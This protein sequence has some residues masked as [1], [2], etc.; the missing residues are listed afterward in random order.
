M[1]VK[2]AVLISILL[3]LLILAA[4]FAALSGLVYA[5]G[6]FLVPKV[7]PLDKII[8]AACNPDEYLP[9][10][11]QFIRALTDY[12]NFL[13]L[14]PYLSWMIAYGLYRL[15]PRFK[16]GL[17]AFL[18]VETIIL[19]VLAA[20]GRIFHNK[21]YT[22]ANVLLVLGILAAFGGA[23]YMFYKMEA[24]AMRRF[25]RLFWLILLS[26]YLTDA[27]ATQRIKAAIARP[28]PLNDANKPWNE[29]LRVVPD[30]ELKG[31][32]SYP[33]GHTSGT[34]ALLTPLFW[35]IRDRRGRAG[36]LTWSVLQGFSRVYTV[37]HFP[38][39]CLMGGILGFGTGTLVFFTLGGPSLRAPAE[40]P[41]AE[42]AA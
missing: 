39:C 38:F 32:N 16:K 31:A 35:F 6:I 12:T 14:A 24:P 17:A 28:R 1:N 5:G 30:E 9:G 8:S 7:D 11:D 34:F 15:L 29:S 19:A 10:A 36:L 37:A 18:G 20:A 40:P 21:T 4:G 2:R 42:S 25:A 41:K 22:G 3:R 23:A 26:G 27:V 33:S 13:I